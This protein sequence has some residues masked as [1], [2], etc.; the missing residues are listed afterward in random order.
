[1]VLTT[2]IW[3]KP[4]LAKSEYRKNLAKTF[5]VELDNLATDHRE[6]S[7]YY[8]ALAPVNQRSSFSVN[9]LVYLPTGQTWQ[10]QF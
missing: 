8:F 6:A 4:P 9:D 7:S 1:M 2:V 10:V 5:V 3:K